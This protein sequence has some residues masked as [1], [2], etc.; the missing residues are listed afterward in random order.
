MSY[1][2]WCRRGRNTEA[3]VCTPFSHHNMPSPPRPLRSLNLDAASVR[4][5]LRRLQKP[6]ARRNAE[7]A[8][9]PAL[10]HIFSLTNNTTSM[11]FSVKTQ[12]TGDTARTG[13]LEVVIGACRSACTNRSPDI[14]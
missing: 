14:P 10:T 3:R 12:E 7:S 2:L 9:T 13:C 8:L 6:R 1:E 5:V 4:F 11:H